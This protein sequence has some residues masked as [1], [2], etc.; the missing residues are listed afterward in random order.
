[1]LE[2]KKQTPGPSTKVT[3][4]TTDARLWEQVFNGDDDAYDEYLK[5][6]TLKKLLEEDMKKKRKL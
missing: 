5:A 2:K 4:K 6:K 1:M 3:G